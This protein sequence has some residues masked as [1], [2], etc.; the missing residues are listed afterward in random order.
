VLLSL[1][2]DSEPWHVQLLIIRI[3]Y[4]CSIRI[5]VKKI[6]CILDGPSHIHI[7]LSSNCWAILIPLSKDSPLRG[8]RPL[9]CI[10]SP[11]GT[12]ECASRRYVL[13]SL[14][15]IL[16]TNEQEVGIP[17]CQS[18]IKDGARPAK[19]VDASSWLDLHKGNEIDGVLDQERKSD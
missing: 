1:T 12:E 3:I 2:A 5:T 8:L 14:L 13:S 7:V 15:T 19:S 18:T 6:L 17:E 4:A 16:W 11:C 10:S 9:G